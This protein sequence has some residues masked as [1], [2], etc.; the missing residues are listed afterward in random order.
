MSLLCRTI[1]S[2]RLAMPYRYGANLVYTEEMVDKRVVA[3]VRQVNERLG[4][5]DFLDKGGAEGGRVGPR[6]GY[7]A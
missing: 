6:G 3:S 4:T 1:C 5:V 2:S 7:T